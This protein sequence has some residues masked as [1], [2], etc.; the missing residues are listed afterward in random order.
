MGILKM[1]WRNVRRNRRRSGVTI[2]AMSLALLVMILYAGLMDGYLQG[3]ER[4]VLDLEVGDLQIF[5]SEYRDRPSLETTI[6]DPAAVLRSLSEAGFAATGRILAF[7]MAAAGES[8]AGVSFRGVDVELD[9]TVSRIGDEVA[10]GSWLDPEDPKGVVLGRRLARTLD[11]APGAEL[12]VLTQSTDGAMAYDLYTV[13]GVLRGI[14]DATDRTGVF[15]TLDALRELVLVPDGVHQIIVRRPG[16]V[17]LATAAAR[18]TSLS[19]EL[20]VQTWRQLLPTIASLLDSAR[21]IMFAMFFIVYVAI[22][23]LIL[24]AMLMAV[25]ERIRELGVLKALGASPFVVLRMILLESGIQTAMAIAIGVSLSVP[26]VLYLATTGID[27]GTLAGTSVVGIAMDPVWR[28]AISPSI[29]TAPVGVL[30]AI[31][32]VAVLYPAFKA[33]FLRPVEALRYH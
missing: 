22:G 6:D 28:A 12:V 33:A 5:A 24:N 32:G 17:E 21:G 10:V 18:V 8:S 30:V 31:V 27:L 1:A 19:G 16:D 4:S 11:V 7:G 9:A 29:F 15:M 25:F 3:M 2:A 20:D 13:R 26:S 14:A 23:I